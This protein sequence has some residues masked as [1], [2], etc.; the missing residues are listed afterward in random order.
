[1]I[2]D[3]GYPR[4]LADERLCDRLRLSTDLSSM[5]SVAT[6]PCNRCN[7]LVSGGVGG[8]ES[9]PWCKITLAQSEDSVNFSR[10]ALS[11]S[12]MR[13]TCF[14][15]STNLVLPR[16]VDICKHGAISQYM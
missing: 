5:D 4:L 1:M 16:Y 14:P 2:C 9:L 3:D 7:H 13:H 8:G 10:A 6:Q 12:A 15:V 11:L